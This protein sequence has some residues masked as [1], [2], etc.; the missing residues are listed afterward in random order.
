MRRHE[1]GIGY[2]ACGRKGTLLPLPGGDG[3]PLG[4]NKTPREELADG[5]SALCSAESAA[6][7]RKDAAMER[8][9]ART[10]RQRV[11]TAQGVG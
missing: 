5:E 9:G 11:R 2:G 1:S 6:R 4:G 10:L 3:A 7:C 8:R